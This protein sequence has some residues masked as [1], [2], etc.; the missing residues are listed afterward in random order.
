MKIRSSGRQFFRAPAG[1]TAPILARMPE[2]PPLT[3]VA[4]VAAEDF[5]K[6]REAII[7]PTLA[8]ELASAIELALL[9]SVRAERR[10]AVGEC[11][12]RAEVWER[13]GERP[14]IT[15][16]LRQEAQHRAN[17]ARYLADLLASRS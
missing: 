6:G 17:E 7:T 13:T 8:R 16:P 11:A 15:E 10:A 5:R 3:D 14:G 4:R 1:E 12:R 9:T 2:I